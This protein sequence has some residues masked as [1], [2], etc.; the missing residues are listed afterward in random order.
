MSSQ[1]PRVSTPLLLWNG[2][3]VLALLGSD[4]ERRTTEASRR[5]MGTEHTEMGE[6]LDEEYGGRGGAR[7]LVRVR[8]SASGFARGFVRA[9]AVT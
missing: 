3:D 2:A 9:R 6:L 8:K 1:N 7:G 5:R 4:I